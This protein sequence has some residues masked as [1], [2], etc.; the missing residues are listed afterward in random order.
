MLAKKAPKAAASARS[1][2]KGAS[3]STMRIS[4][5]NAG[6]LGAVEVKLDIGTGV[7]PA[8]SSGAC[9]AVDYLR[10]DYYANPKTS[11]VT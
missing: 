8:A 1:P 9:A 3:F 4:V 5:T 2:A 7:G 10:K 6:C 11:E